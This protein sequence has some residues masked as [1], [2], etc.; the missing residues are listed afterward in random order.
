MDVAGAGSANGFGV[1][2]GA[3]MAEDLSSVVQHSGQ[4]HPQSHPILWHWV[5]ADNQIPCTVAWKRRC[6]TACGNYPQWEGSGI[7]L[8]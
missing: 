5:E 1:R 4:Q 3:A 7:A 6:G 8:Q 2:G